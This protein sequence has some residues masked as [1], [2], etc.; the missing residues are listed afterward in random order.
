MQR[1]SRE[2]EVRNV[3]HYDAD[4]QGDKRYEKEIFARIGASAL[5]EVS[6]TRT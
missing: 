2:S 6:G 3:N 1:I 5:R 4:N